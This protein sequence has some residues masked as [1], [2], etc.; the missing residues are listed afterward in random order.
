MYASIGFK[1]SESNPNFHPQSYS[2][3]G[4]AAML[5]SST[6][7]TYSL[8]VIMLET[9]SN[10]DLFV[11]MIFA[12]SVSY[13]V[14]SLF[15]RSLYSGALRQKNIPFLQQDIPVENEDKVAEDIMTAPVKTFKPLEDV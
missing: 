11:P 6:R 7:M 14:G 5:S 8:A 15:T 13:G 1:I 10:V 12:L 2:L 4:A 3:I 9:T